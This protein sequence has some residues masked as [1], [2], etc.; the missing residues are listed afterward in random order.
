M[1][2]IKVMSAIVIK[3]AYTQL[4]AHFERRFGHAIE[5]EWLPSI[6]I[7]QRLK[8]GE[9]A[10]LFFMSR[11][12]IEEL[13]SFEVVEAN[14]IVNLAK[15]GIGVAVRE[16]TPLPK[17]KTVEEFRGALLKA[18][19]IAYS[20]GPSGDYL[21]GLFD[22]LGL[23]TA[24]EN[25]TRVIKDEPVAALVAR[26]EI[27]LGFQQKSEI[28][29]ISGVS[30]V[31]P[32]PP[33]IQNYTTIAVGQHLRASSPHAAQQWVDFL[34]RPESSQAINQTGLDAVAT[35][36]SEASETVARRV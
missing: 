31:G 24:L 21:I 26:G 16:G 36:E 6:D 12:A 29:P 35:L 2:K 3:A 32:L 25:K 33:E 8:A 23:S 4:A 7:R 5:T 17:I 1:A 28:L 18:R 22:R 14:K 20:T 19:S 34:L 10:D 9:I 30:Y 13:V 15:A 11:E 27:D